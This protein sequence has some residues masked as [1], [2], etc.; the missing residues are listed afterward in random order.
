M[1]EPPF[2][3]ILSLVGAFYSA[4]DGKYQGPQAGAEHC[5]NPGFKSNMVQTISGM[6]TLL[7]MNRVFDQACSQVFSALS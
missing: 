5:A 1:P 4:G 7:G 6:I 2:S 3:P